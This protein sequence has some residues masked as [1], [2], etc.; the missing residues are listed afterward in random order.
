MQILSS[1]EAKKS[2]NDPCGVGI[3]S[4]EAERIWPRLNPGSQAG[5]GVKLDWEEVVRQGY[6]RHEVETDVGSLRKLQ[7]QEVSVE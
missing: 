2:S 1:A 5:L 4:R 3:R 7:G 6:K